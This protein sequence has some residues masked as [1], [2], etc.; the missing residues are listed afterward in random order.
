M[1]FVHLQV[2]SGYSLLNS[3][4]SVE[5]LTAKAEELGYSALAL[6]DDEVMYGAVEFYKACKKRGIKPIIGLTAAVLTDEKEQIAYPLVL[7]AKTNKGYKNLL[8]ISSVLQSKSKTGIK[9]KWLKSYHEDI[10]ALTTGE[11][12]YVEALLKEG[13]LEEAQEAALRYKSIFGEDSFYLSYQ[14]YKADPLLSKRILELSATTGIPVA[15]SG[16]VRYIDKE[17]VTAYTCLK[18]IKAGEKH[19]GDLQAEGDQ[20]LDLK[21][22]AEMLD[23]YRDHPDALE[24]TVKIAGQCCVDLSLGQTRLP[25]YPAPAGRN[26]DDYLAELC[27][28]G[29]SKR[30]A[31]P[32]HEYVSRLEYELSVIKDMAFSD[33]FLIVWDFMKFAHENGIITGPGRGSAAGSLVAYALFIT[34]VDPIKHKLLFERFLNPE[35]ISMPDIDIDF[36]D[37]RR[38]EVIQYVKDKYGAL[39]VAQIITFG[40]LAAKAALR[41][42]G[43]VMGISPKEADQLAKLIPSKPGV[44]LKEA[45]ELSSELAKR[46]NESKRLQEIFKTAQKIE[47][48]P[49]HTS[50]HAAGVVLSEEP[51]TNIIPIQ[52]GHDGVYLTQYSMGYLEDLGLLK[53]DFLG[54]RNLTLIESIKSMIEKKERITIDFSEISYEDDQTF[55]LLSKGDTTGIFQLESAG[56]RNVLK[57][58]KPTSLEDIVAVNALYRPGPMEN[59]PLYI[60]RKHGQAPVHYPHEDLAEILKDTYG[61]IVYQEQIMMIASQMAG[62]RLGEADLLRRAVGKKN[63]EILDTER[64]HFINGCLKK[65]YS[66]KS[67][68]EVYD[69]IV[70]FANYGFNRSHA[71]AYS[72]IGYQLAYLKAH[73]P[74]YFMCGLLTSAIGNEEKLAQYIYE[75]KGK[76]LDILGPSVNKSGYPFAVENGALRYSLRAVKGVGISA[77][78]EIYRARKEKPFADLF[79]FCVRTSVKSVNRKTIE[80]LIFSGA[81][82]EFGENRATLLASIDIALEHAELFAGDHD[83]LGFFLDEA[84]TIKPKYAETEEMPLVDL[85]AR[86]K[87]TLGIYFSNH[88]L[89]VHRTG[90]NQA[91]ALPI[92]QL[93]GSS[94][95][96]AALGAL[97]TKMKTIRTKAG[98]TMA[99]LEL[100]DE[101]GEM[102]AVVFPEQLRQFSPILKEG[103]S[104]FAEGRLETR[105]EKR[106]LIVTAASLLESLH[107]KKQPS[108]YI[109]V[110][111][112]QH[113]QEMLEKISSLL[114]ENK[115]ETP[116][117]IYYEKKKQTMKLPDAYN[118]KA[119]HAVL[120]RLK[121]VVGEKNVVLR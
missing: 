17:D 71:V 72:M 30:F 91:G 16:D 65:G 105:N 2:H 119:D 21:P 106:Q 75:A 68:N 79:D 73:F 11:T 121:S 103:A 10:I 59:I 117:C 99:F 76:G 107:T 60:E 48:L 98:Q 18:A 25:K 114:L 57:K 43:R 95:K 23:I 19:D 85:L 47:G 70:K 87:E 100:S 6:T 66:A 112:N 69:L 96:K 63:K 94:Q 77:V 58:L 109:K 84:M 83:Q 35:R 3:A 78:K 86:E 104:I 31:D 82:D 111:E 90:L 88:P 113:T 40:T 24:N 26:A 36:P 102:E 51:L 120:Y 46:L 101:S 38:D 80:A 55:Q 81:M 8:K 9:E 33:Y 20:N 29:L 14:P 118:I 52:E 44:T 110:E 5:D 56:M 92:I 45:R 34:D 41:D 4:A 74:L 13:L 53:M 97:L 67:A 7:L 54:L 1:P 62:F 22:P 116:V 28:A 32:P 42:V 50:I 27:F 115:G 49:R 12:S 108:V 61:V 93:L 15:A 64:N 37:V 89:S 39:H